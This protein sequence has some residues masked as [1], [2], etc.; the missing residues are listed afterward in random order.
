MHLTWRNVY[1]KINFFILGRVWVGRADN[2]RT[3]DRERVCPR[4]GR[5]EESKLSRLR[6][7]RLRPHRVRDSGLDPVVVR[8]QRRSH[9]GLGRCRTARWRSSGLGKFDDECDFEDRRRNCLRTNNKIC[10]HPSLSSKFILKYRK[11]SIKQFDKK[12]SLFY[13]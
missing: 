5:S 2:V 11:K 8:A 9:R 1:K 6:S 7:R 10:K 12:F 4:F 3:L 13:L